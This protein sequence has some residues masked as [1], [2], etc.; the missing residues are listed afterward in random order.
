VT[1]SLTAILLLGM[2]VP[3]LDVS[4]LPA[5]NAPPAP[6]S[7]A[8]AP[9]KYWGPF[10]TTS[11]DV[12]IDVN[13]TGIAVRVEIPREFLDGVITQENDT[14]FIQSD[15]R[16]D[17]YYYSVVD[18][19]RHWSYGWNGTDSDAP[20]YKPNFSIYDPTAPWC[21]EIWN[22]LNGTFKTFTP[23][24]F[25]R[26]I[27]LNT[28][29]VAGVYNFTLF[30][31]DHT[32]Q[33]GLPDFVNAWNKTFQ[34]P[35]SMN[36]NPAS[37]TGTIC[38]SD[39]HAIPG[40][41][42]TILAK[43]VVYARNINTGQESRVYVNQTTGFF[44][45][46]GLAPGDYVIQGSAGIFHG[47]AYSFSRAD[48]TNSPG[49][50]YIVHNLN[51]GSS[52]SM[53][54]LPLARSPQACGSIEYYQS[55]SLTHLS[56]SL[57]DHP[58]L[59]NAGIKTLNI[60]VEA[61]DQQGH[62][63]RYQNVSLDLASDSFT[64]ITGGGVKY[65]GLDPY[66]TEFAG[67][68]G[69]AAAYPLN[70]TVWITGYLQSVSEFVRGRTPAG[71]APPFCTNIVS[72]SPIVMKTGG[73]ITGTIQLLGAPPI[74]GI[75][76]ETP[77]DGEVTLGLVPTDALFGGNIL[78]QAWDHTGTL[79]GITVLNG[80][81]PDGRTCYASPALSPLCKI[82]IISPTTI[83]FF[84]IGFS[85]HYNR[86]WS[87]TWGLKDTG[88]PQDQGYQLTV[89]MR[90]YEQVATSPFA[91]LGGG[92]QSVTI[93]MVRGGAISVGVFSWDNRPGGRSLQALQPFRFISLPY[94]ARAR[95]YFY[96]SAGLTV[97]YV[98]RLMR[99]G[100]PNGLATPSS[101][102]AVFAG[103]NRSPRE[104][105]FYGDEPTHLTNDTYTV[106]AYTL[107]YVQQIQDISTHVDLAGFATVL[108]AL[109]LGNEID[110]VTPVF[111]Q[112]TLFGNLPEHDHGVAETYLG[113]LT[114]AVPAN[115]TEG[116]P[117]IDFP[118]FGFGG[119]VQDKTFNGQGHFFYV[120][121]DGTR[122]FDYGLDVGNYTTQVPEFGFNRHFTPLDTV[123]T[124]F[125]DLF[126]EQG[127][128]LEI[129]SM[130]RIIS[131]T[132]PVQGWIGGGGSVGAVIP[133]SWVTV[134][135]RSGTISRSVP[136]LDGFY[137]GPGAINLPG[138]TYNITFSV[139]FY[140]PQTALNIPV[141]WG[142]D[143][144]VLPPSG[145]LCPIVDPSV[146]TSS[147]S[148]QPFSM[149][150]APIDYQMIAFA[151]TTTLL[152][153]FTGGILLIYE[154]RRIQFE[155]SAPPI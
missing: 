77:H 76:P 68:P 55:P 106:K 49:C 104:I 145:F 26:F 24:K 118:I 151:Q 93:Q 45:L 10:F 17:Y 64:I 88:L 67:L 148:F 34:V 139:A 27:G 29:S 85:E 83:R 120:T 11:G 70:V 129:I 9:T 95:I 125:T 2:L 90:G 142:G 136:T 69:I 13:R 96:S 121:H 62:V 116:A 63:Y 18:E 86:T 80:T 134:Q 44:N 54:D 130:A 33:L 122:Y 133:L 50:S 6:N 65:V 37:I 48:C 59:K 155:F 16:N 56:H 51:R 146:C 66:G 110:L 87:G 101:F 35:V 5:V 28:P 12:Q 143:Y 75:R 32:N 22:N 57:S 117:S 61:T 140:Q 114:G 52:I 103:Q 58:Y 43:G 127:S 135:A 153:L 84:I 107:G 111:S 41:C 40:I 47:V 105:W 39:N 141:Q 46:T 112:P 25:V 38:D 72:P 123:L 98:E 31:A 152:V 144:V 150:Q 99:L 23:P 108:I 82:K 113:S 92:N 78:I 7:A 102:T 42:P 71:Q 36:D 109:L 100:V 4:I 128:V 131:S 137:D 115:M 74:N 89:F 73:V 3:L 30:V 97:G 81:L 79:R 126:L 91:L 132:T 21:V 20:C 53:G 154:R 8:L 15:I 94:P 14:H 147:G 119:M 138:G 124:T 19:S 149:V 60:T 1:A